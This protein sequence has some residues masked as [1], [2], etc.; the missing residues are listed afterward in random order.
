MI[1]RHIF[2]SLILIGLAAEVW[3]HIDIEME[4]YYFPLEPMI[5]YCKFADQCLHDFVSV[6]GQDNL[7]ITRM[8][9]D[10]CDLNEYNCDEKKQYRHVKLDICKY[11]LVPAPE[12][13]FNGP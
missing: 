13:F 8:F 11:E 4:D 10:V 1:V 9:V 5:N 12:F 2:T 7:G 3:S 6:C